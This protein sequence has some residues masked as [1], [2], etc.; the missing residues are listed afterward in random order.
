M[1][2]GV[3]MKEYLKE[4]ERRKKYR[5]IPACI[6]INLALTISLGLWINSIDK[7]QKRRLLPIQLVKQTIMDQKQHQDRAYNRRTNRNRKGF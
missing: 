3:K 7:E 5:V 6:S 1:F 4:I 2:K